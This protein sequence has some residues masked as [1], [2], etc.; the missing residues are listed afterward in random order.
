MHADRVIDY[1][2]NFSHVLTAFTQKSGRAWYQNSRDLR[3]QGVK[4]K[5]RQAKGQQNLERC[6]SRWKGKAL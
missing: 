2:V 5:C 1:D 6:R 4:Y 3:H